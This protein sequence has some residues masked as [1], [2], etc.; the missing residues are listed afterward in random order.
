[1]ADLL[2]LRTAGSF[3]KF[4]SGNLHVHTLYSI[5]NYLEQEVMFLGVSCLFVFLCLRELQS[6]EYGS[7]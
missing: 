6:N 1:M 7:F 2:S 4:S 3:W 5:I